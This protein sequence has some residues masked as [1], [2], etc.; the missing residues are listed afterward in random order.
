[1]LCGNIQHFHTVSCW[2]YFSIEKHQRCKKKYGENFQKVIWQKA[3]KSLEKRYGKNW[4][5]IN[6]QKSIKVF[7]S[8]LNYIKLYFLINFGKKQKSKTIYFSFS[9][10][11]KFSQHLLKY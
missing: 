11:Y 2:S 6:A 1:M 4:A 3:I 5:K 8:K 7:K 9:V 10:H